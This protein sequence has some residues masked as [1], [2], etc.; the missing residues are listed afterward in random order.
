MKIKNIFGYSVFFLSIAI[1][2]C[3]ST[4][5]VS[6][7]SLDEANLVIDRLDE[8][9]WYDAYVVIYIDN[10]YEGQISS[11]SRRL[12]KIDTVGEHT[13]RVEFKGPSDRSDVDY[14]HFETYNFEINNNRLYFTIDHKWIDKQERMYTGELKF[15]RNEY[16]LFDKAKYDSVLL[17]SYQDIVNN[18]KPDSRIAVVNISTTDE[19]LR[20]YFID[21]LVQ[22]F[23]N[24][25]KFDVIDRR[26]LDIIRNEHNFQMSGEV[27]DETIVGIGHFLAAE[28]VI[29]GEII[30]EGI[31]NTFRLKVLD[32]R[33][34]RLIGISIHDL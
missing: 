26:N 25:N 23:V 27:S 34:A 24:E 9:D 31:Q 4:S 5:Y 30:N 19:Y 1:N 12:F 16:K 14:F 28:A 7:R 6:V 20:N 11:K 17:A 3:I 10:Q 18:I 29:S 21:K 13:I 32:V 22:L 8:Y 2:S 15:V 33:T